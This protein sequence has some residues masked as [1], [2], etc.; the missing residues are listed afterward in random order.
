M[1]AGN[2]PAR[3]RRVLEYLLTAVFVCALGGVSAITTGVER[4]GAYGSLTPIDLGK[5]PGDA[6]AEVSL[7]NSTG[8]VAGVSIGGPATNIS[9]AF[10]WT[11]SGGMVWLGGGSTKP[12]AMSDTGQIV[13]QSDGGAF[14]WT[15][16]GGMVD[17]GSL[18]PETSSYAT[19]VNNHGEVVGYSFTLASSSSEHAFRWTADGGMVDLGTLGGSESEAWGISDSGQIAGYSRTADGTPHAFSWTPSGG[20]VDLGTL[21]GTFSGVFAGE[22]QIISGDGTVVGYAGLAGD[23]SSDAFAWTAADGMVDLGFAGSP[24][25]NDVGMIAAPS[26]PYP[27]SGKFLSPTSGLVDM[28]SLGGGLTNLADMNNA[29]LVVGTSYT[30]GGFEHMFAWD[31]TDGMFDLGAGNRA[32]AV[33]D[34]NLIGGSG[35][36]RVDGVWEQHATVWQ[37]A[38]VP[39]VDSD[40]PTISLDGPADGA[41]YALGASVHAHYSCSDAMSGVA[42]CYG[43]VANGDPLDTTTLGTHWISVISTDNANNSTSVTHAYTVVDV[44]PPSVTIYAPPANAFY[45]QGDQVSTDYTCADRPGESGVSTCNGPVEAGTLLDTSTPG[46]HTFTVDASDHASNTISATHTYTVVAP[47]AVSTTLPTGGGVLTTDSSNTGPTASVPLHTAVTSPTG[48]DVSI[49][50]GAA[51]TSAPEGYT[52]FGIQDTITAPQS[53]ATSPLTLRFSI[54]QALLAS[55]GIDASSVVI[56]RDG[57]PIDDCAHAG[58][59]GADPDPCVFSRVTTAGGDAD[60]RVYSTHASRWNIGR[61]LPSGPIAVSPPVLADGRVG[62]A[63]SA[64]ATASGGADPYSWTIA[65]GSLPPGLLLDGSTGS[66]SGTPASAGTFVFALKAQDSL[67]QVGTSQFAVTISPPPDSTKGKLGVWYS[68]TVPPLAG[69]PPYH[70]AVSSGILPSGVTLDSATGVVSGMPTVEGLAKFAV[71]VT[72]SKLPRNAAHVTRFKVL[73]APGA[74]DIG[75]ASLPN[76]SRLVAYSA[77]LAGSGG[78]PIYRFKLVAGTMPI[79]VRLRGTG[80]LVGTPSVAGTYTFTVMVTDRWHFTATRTYTIV[81]T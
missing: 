49:A 38:N 4:A 22:K 81:V 56:F 63:Y 2:H 54:D 35:L 74:L 30:G 24:L 52:I 32:Y 51:D 57:A 25:T 67:S 45:A 79:G 66:I 59:V 53:D 29:G 8:Q 5:L 44:V 50:Q 68:T 3:P 33:N 77:A 43:S 75:P 11:Q 18:N 69:V 28:G 47:V 41:T 39:L 23:A 17:L 6:Y 15:E 55:A 19:A 20:M 26:G 21:G 37:F 62:L 58:V 1:L 70:F 13:G 64:T 72:D 27:Y 12:T 48:G 16:A 40:P 42:T 10:S 78:V 65:K 14:S 76:A 31:A 80:T 36:W 61:A 9:H 73:I 46:V 34:S 71:K 7:V 60:I